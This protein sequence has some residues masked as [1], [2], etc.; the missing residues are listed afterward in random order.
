MRILLDENIPVQLKSVFI[1]HEVRSV[2]DP[3][4]G[5]KNLAN[6]R[7]LAEMEGRFDMLITADR[8]MFAQQNLTGRSDPKDGLAAAL[9]RLG[10]AFLARSPDFYWSAV[11]AEKHSPEL[12]LP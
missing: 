4:V 12:I 5:W 9:A 10:Q 3:D 7:L 1:G 6:G 11:D 2:N 8:N